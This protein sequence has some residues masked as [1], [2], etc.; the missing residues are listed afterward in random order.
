MIARPLLLLAAACGNDVGISPLE[1]DAD[2]S[3]LAEAPVPRVLEV[4]EP[5]GEG[6][7][8]ADSSSAGRRFLLGFMEDATVADPKELLFELWI[9]SPVATRGTYGIGTRDFVVH[10]EADAGITRLFLPSLLFPMVPSGS[11]RVEARGQS[12]K[13]DD[14]VQIVAFTRRGGHSE[15]T[16]LR[17]V[18]ELGY[19]YRVAAVGGREG[20]SELVV[21]AG[22]DDTLVT[23]VPSALTVDGQPADLAYQ[24]VLDEA[25]THQVQS[26]QDLSGTRIVSSERVA[27]FGGARAVEVDCA[28]AAHVWEQLPPRSRFAT[29]W[30]VAPWQPEQDYGYAL[31]L[32]DVD[33]TE[34]T[35]DCAPVAALDAG[36]T[37][38]IR[39]DGASRLRASAPVL[40]M[41]LT[42]GGACGEGLGKPDLQ[43]ASPTALYR[44][45]LQV[46]PRDDAAQAVLFTGVEPVEPMR[47]DLD[48][49]TEVREPGL[50]GF[51][52][53]AAA[54]DGHA[55]GIGWDCVGC[56]SALQAP[57]ACD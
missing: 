34:V 14:P 57:A 13:M 44:D 19:D 42:V 49:P 6:P 40:V 5:G 12:I 29:D 33:D 37:A 3:G 18:P 48:G 26:T 23:V 43:L 47:L 32:A 28:G 10:V 52:Y 36:E 45:G 1:G 55:R 31:V 20:L 11:G 25:Q 41:Q 27:V 39:L 30:L 8:G 56:A 46:E 50:R 4:P 38:R 22:V 15:A 35:L 54:G 17:P 2:A 7:T 16:R 9:E 53:A 24:V 51:V 21:V